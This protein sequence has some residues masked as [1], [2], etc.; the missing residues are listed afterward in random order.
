MSVIVLSVMVLIVMDLIQIFPNVFKV[1]GMLASKNLVPG[2]KV[3][4]ERLVR[5]K[6]KEYRLWEPS[7]SKLGAALAKGLKNM[8]IAPGVSVLYLGAANGT[9]CSHVSDILG[10]KGELYCVEFAPHSMRDLLFLCEKRKNMLPILADARMPEKYEATV[11]GKVDVIF[12]DVSDPAQAEI[13]I[14]NARLLKKEGV[15]LIAVKSRSVSSSRSPQDVYEEVEVKLK[16]K[17]E[18]IEKLDLAP[19]EADHE[20][21]VLKQKM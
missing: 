2:V 6:G 20:F 13:M 7:R 21:L 17:F 11:G 5:E 1:N 4:G 12:E 10:E 14:A 19:F 15:A 3:Y 16:E 18:I 8:P 9:T